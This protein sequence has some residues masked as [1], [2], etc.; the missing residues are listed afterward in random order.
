VA[1]GVLARVQPRAFTL[2]ELLICIAIIALLI[3]ILIPALA[4]ARS[5]ARS[6]ICL[7]RMQ[8]VAVGWQLYADANDDVSVPG[9]VGRYADPAKNLYHVGNGIQYRPRWYVQMGAEAGFFALKNPLPDPAFEHSAQIGNDAFLCP[10][11]ADWTSTRNSPYGYN[12]QFLGNARFRGDV[13]ANGFINFPVRT[14]SIDAAG[15]VMFADC[16]GS[17]AGKPRSSRLPNQPDGSRHP[18]LLAMGG[19]AYSLDPPR[20]SADGDFCDPLNAAPE[21]R[22]APD[23]RHSRKANA[24][25][26][27]GHAQTMS[28]QEMGYITAPDGSFTSLDPKASNVLFSGNRLDGEVPAVGP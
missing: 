13:E 4:A 5:A 2:I 9:Q 15:T 8:Q 20:L 16:M 23:P 14:S 11:A 6:T 28:V 27:D 10:E 18:Q 1:A 26:C 25:F 21:H 24:A 12:Y 17:A 19:H 3:A 7:S 22:S